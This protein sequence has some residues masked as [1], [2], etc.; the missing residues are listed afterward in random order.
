VPDT[1]AM[2]APLLERLDRGDVVT[3]RLPGFG[4]PLP[5]G[6]SSTKDEYAAWVAGA[7]RDLGEPVDL[8]GHDWGALLSQRVVNTEPALIRTWALADGVVSR[9]FRW[10]DLAVQWQTPGVGEQVMELMTGDALVA[11]LGAAGHPA[12][13]VAAAHIDPEMKRAILALYRSAVD[14][15]TEWAPAGRVERPGLV[16][17]GRDDPYGSTANAAR[18]AELSGAESITLAGGHWAPVERPDETATALHALWAR[19]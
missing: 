19:G 1:A 4:A 6:F 7:L 17:W 2:W 5:S 11:G 15:A 12:P 14:L 10:H 8:V 18:V 16:L 9:E 13:E 3:L